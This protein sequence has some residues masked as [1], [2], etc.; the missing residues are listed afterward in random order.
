MRFLLSVILFLSFSVQAISKVNVVTTLTDLAWAAKEIG[1]DKVQVRAL[2]KGVEDPHYLDARPDFIRWAANANIVCSVG[3][4]LE[5]GWLPKVLTRSGNRHVQPGGKGYCVTGQ[6]IQVLEK[7]SGRVDRSM[8]D[9]HPAGN[10]HYW[11]SPVELANGA[12]VIMDSLIG[13]D[14][15]NAKFYRERWKR[16]K[17]RLAALQA[18]NRSRIVKALKGKSQPVVIQYHKDFSY[19]FK[20][21]GLKSFGSIEEKPGIPPSAGR[22]AVVANS[23]KNSSV[24]FILATELNPTSTLKRLSE[25]TSLPIVQV[26]ISV[27]PKGKVKDYIKFQKYLVNRVIEALAGSGDSGNSGKKR[28]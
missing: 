7:P 8:G 18:T 15:G 20:A 6:A 16:L 1:A 4:D 3:L 10:P 14:P 2:L 21:H 22:L 25:L 24:K 12:R 11:L 19:F 17:N 27:Q 13:A 9:V 28:N 26:P 5:I 23:L